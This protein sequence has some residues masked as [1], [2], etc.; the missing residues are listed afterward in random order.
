MFALVIKFKKKLLK[1]ILWNGTWKKIRNQFKGKRF[2]QLSLHVSYKSTLVN[3]IWNDF[4]MKNYTWY[5]NKYIYRKNDEVWYLN[6]KY[7]QNLFLLC[8]KLIIDYMPKKIY[9]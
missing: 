6:F 8:Y 1:N 7:M 9:C 3:L 2:M 5:K 4:S